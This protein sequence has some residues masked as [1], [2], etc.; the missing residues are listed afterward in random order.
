MLFSFLRLSC[1]VTGVHFVLLI[2]SVIF[3]PI[4]FLFL[5]TPLTFLFSCLMVAAMVVRSITF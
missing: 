2:L 3:Y 1:Y 5:Y 4:D